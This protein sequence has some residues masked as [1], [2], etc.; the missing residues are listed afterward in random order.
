[1]VMDGNGES[2]IIALWLVSSEDKSTIEFLMDVFK[3]LFH[4]LRS[5]RR[6]MSTEKMGITAA[7]RVTV[8]DLLSKLAY[9]QSEE[10]Y[11]VINQRC[12]RC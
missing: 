4:T 12:S 9:A 6:E 7:Q 5:F 1:M 8:L 10:T 2:E 11:Q 3:S